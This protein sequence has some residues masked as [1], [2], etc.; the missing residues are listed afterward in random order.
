MVKISYERTFKN[1]NTIEEAMEMMDEFILENI[2]E[3]STVAD[4]FD[5]EVI[6][7]F[8]ECEYD[9]C[10]CLDKDGNLDSTQ[11]GE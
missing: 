9:D 10:I 8:S 2:R 6:S 1:L 3:Y 5:Y 4:M 7:E 11:E